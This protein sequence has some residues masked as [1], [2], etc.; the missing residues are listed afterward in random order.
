MNSPTNNNNL[1][2]NEL[3]NNI[4]ASNFNSAINYQTPKNVNP[5]ANYFISSPSQYEIPQNHLSPSL[6]SLLYPL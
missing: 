4:S 6:N 2:F 5:Q 1:A 3:L